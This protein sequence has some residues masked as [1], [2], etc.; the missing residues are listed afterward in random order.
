MPAD[1]G[2]KPTPR[3]EDVIML[4]EKRHILVLGALIALVLVTA[5]LLAKGQ[6]DG[7]PAERVG[8]TSALFRP[9]NPVAV[10]ELTPGR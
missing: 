5:M 7:G 8:R 1:R 10:S 6:R 3:P 2:N 9:S 4:T